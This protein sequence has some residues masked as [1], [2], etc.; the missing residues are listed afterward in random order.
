[1]KKF[2][3]NL[4]ELYQWVWFHTEFWLTPKERRPYTFIWRDWIYNNVGLFTLLT[5]LFHVI[6]IIISIEHGTAT[7][8]IVMFGDFL[9]AH[10]IWGTVWIEG[11]QE[12]PEYF[13]NIDDNNDNNG[14]IVD[15]K[16]EEN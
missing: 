14:I 5:I 16:N 10:L 12:Y 4:G 6:I 2:T 1:M 8:I 15:F 3:I 11:E 13:G 9:L 7:T